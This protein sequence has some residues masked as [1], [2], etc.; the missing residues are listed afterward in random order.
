MFEKEQERYLTGRI[1]FLKGDGRQ[2]ITGSFHPI[3][4]GEWS[5]QAYV[6]PIAKLFSYIASHNRSA[7]NDF[8]KRN[9][10]AIN[11][12]D[13][14]GRTPLQ[15]A[16]LCSAEEI[17]LELIEQGGRMTSRM[18]DGRCS[19]H[20]AAQMG[21]PK[22]VKALLEKS[23]KNKAEK[24]AK[25]MEIKE[26]EGKDKDVQMKDQDDEVRDSSEDDWSSEDEE[27]KDYEEAKK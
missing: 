9:A 20:L 23:E 5:E 13:Q 15:F 17:C 8:L 18:V 1:S 19:L 16:L 24:E 11:T 27:D 25:E 2:S 22:V 6:K 4:S 7:C 26:S 10:D 3:Y 14:L 12:R 21:L